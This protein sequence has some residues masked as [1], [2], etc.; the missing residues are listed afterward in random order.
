MAVYVGYLVARVYRFPQRS[1]Q[2]FC[3]G[4][5]ST[6]R[7]KSS[8]DASLISKRN[9]C[10]HGGHAQSDEPGWWRRRITGASLMLA[11]DPQRSITP[12]SGKK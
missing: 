11:A 2:I 7:L 10:L 5:S 6:L 8:T 3:T 4:Y 12:S 9:G 1:E